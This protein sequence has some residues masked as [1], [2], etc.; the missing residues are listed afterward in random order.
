MFEKIFKIFSP[1]TL[2][3][4]VAGV[5]YFA[6]AAFGILGLLLTVHHYH[7]SWKEIIL[8]IISVNLIGV[9]NCYFE[10]LSKDF[11]NLENE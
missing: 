11:N 8:I 7:T 3:K 4:I 6:V 1:E 5:V 2:A 10:F 9:L